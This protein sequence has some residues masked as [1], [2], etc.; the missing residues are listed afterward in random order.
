MACSWSSLVSGAKEDDGEG[1]IMEEKKEETK[2]LK[3][4]VENIPILN[5]IYWRLT[6]PR[7]WAQI[8][9]KKYP[10]KEN[11][12]AGA[13]FM[14]E[15]MYLGLIIVLIPKMRY[16]CPVCAVNTTV[17]IGLNFS[18][19]NATGLNVTGGF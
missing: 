6:T 9:M 8:A 4:V 10:G 1:I 14:L 13:S 16:Y 19:L 18:A 2:S 5:V 12:F 11:W 7:T 17:D 15:F 3:E